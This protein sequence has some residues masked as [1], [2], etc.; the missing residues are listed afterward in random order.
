MQDKYVFIDRDGVINKDGDGWTEHGYITRWEDFHFIPGVLEAFA[1]FT[2]AGYKSVIISNQKC[3]G[4]G[5]MSK[6]ALDEI[7]ENLMKSAEEHGG[8]I[9]GVYYCPHVDE[10]GCD[11]R[12]PKEGLF[13]RARKDLG[14]KGLEGKYFIGDSQ[15]DMQAGRKV[16]LKTILVLSGKASR[17][18]AETW[19]HRPDHVCEDLLEAAEL[20]IK[21]DMA[22][23]RKAQSA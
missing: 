7:T 3:V 23:K 6:S 21:S 9:A 22:A 4:K 5:L 14:I 2:E 1:K 20:V 16:G 17:R 19:E 10:D 11:C 12:K 8:K 13:L 15:R 18:D